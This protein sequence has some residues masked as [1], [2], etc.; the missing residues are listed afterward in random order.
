MRF[1]R[2]IPVLT[3][4]C[5]VYPSVAG[6]ELKIGYIDSDEILAKHKPFQEGEK[7]VQRYRMELEKEFTKRQ[8]ELEKMTE[9]YGRQALLLSEKRKKEEQRAILQKQEELQRYLSEI[10]APQDG[11]LA[12]KSKEVLAP[13]INR[14]NIV[15]QRLAKESGYDFVF[16]SSTLAYASETHDLT[17]KVLEEL[18]KELEAETKQSDRP[19]R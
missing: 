16:N 7:D 6:A 1:R 14:V 17:E 18:Q 5:I 19:G 2:V 13:I 9:T 11:K 8:N 4:C 12:R 10:S 15:V 3:A